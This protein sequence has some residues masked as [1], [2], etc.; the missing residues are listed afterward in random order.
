M[1]SFFH[2][3]RPDGI[4]PQLH[5]DRGIHGERGET[6]D[7]KTEP[8]RYP[9][10]YWKGIT[11]AGF[12]AT[13]WFPAR[14][15]VTGPEAYTLNSVGV[16]TQNVVK[17]G[18]R[19]Q[20]WESDHPVKILNVVCGRWQVK[21]GHGTTIYYSSMHLTTWTR[22]PRRS[23]PRAGG[24]R[25][26]PSVSLEG[27]QAL[28]VPGPRRYA[29]GFGTNITFSETSF[30]TRNDTKTDATFMVTAHEAA[31]QWWG[32]PRPP[33]APTATS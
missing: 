30:L 12:G 11:R 5:A 13:A 26:V 29:Q 28:R 33:T 17:N 15:A 23:T 4:H 2:Q 8:R 9:R 32:K 18:W 3:A 19:T 25:V 31:H 6:K 27:A 1:S 22:C 10:D 16:C 20:V 21:Q 14:I 7:N 24:I